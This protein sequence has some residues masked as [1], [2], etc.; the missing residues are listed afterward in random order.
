MPA[1]LDDVDL[2]D[3]DLFADGFPHDV[4]TLLRD[5][6]PV[7]WHRPTERAPGGEGFWVISR[8]A[9]L[10]AVLHDPVTFSSETGPGRVGGGTTLDD[11]PP[12]FVTGVMLNMSDPP[13]HTRQRGLVNKVFTPR[14]VDALEPWLRERAAAVVDAAVEAGACDLLVDVAAELPLQT[15]AE[16]LGVP[17]EDRHQ[18]FDWTSTILDYRDRDLTGTSDELATAGLGLRAYG[19]ELIA[20]RRAGPTDDLLSLVVHATTGDADGSGEVQAMS[21]AELQA[22]FSLLFTAGSETTRNS[23]AGGVLALVEHPAQWTLLRERRDLV[24]GA[25]EEVLRWTSATAYNRRTATV[26][27]ELGGQAIRAGDKTTHWYPS[28]NRDADVF[29]DPFRFDVERSPNPHVAFGHGLHHCLGASLARREVRVV[30]EALLDRVAEVQLTGAPEW[31]RSNKHTSLRHV[32]VSFV[33][34]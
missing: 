11:L 2:T 9:D 8:H 30:L 25:V 22:F 7:W 34:A 23:I 10:L 6:A 31:G 5:E 32:P 26:D 14:A 29:L 20:E 18:L 13:V 12:D 17:Q 1:A 27:V 33:P 28:A 16:V 3:L 15:I 4:F 24:P 19:D 21:A